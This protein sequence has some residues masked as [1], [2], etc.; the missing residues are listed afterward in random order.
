MLVKKDKYTILIII[1]SVLLV[2]SLV[3]GSTFAWFM[4]TDTAS[5][6]IVLGDPVEMI[7][8]DENNADSEDLPMV[9]PGS[10]LVPGMQVTVLAKVLFTQSNTPALLRAQIGARITNS[11]ADAQD[12]ADI[13]TQ[14]TAAM[15]S[16]VSSAGS[17]KWVYN[18][19]DD[20]WY[21][22]GANVIEGTTDQ[23]IMARIDAT[24]E[25]VSSRLVTFFSSSFVFPY[26][27]GNEF[28]N[29]DVEFSVEFQAVQG[30]LPAYTEELMLGENEFAPLD[31]YRINRI[32]NVVDIFNEAFAG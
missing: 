3:V 24:G 28:A 12:I 17:A 23:S 31:D 22:L 32:A 26:V 4:S 30:Y 9:I 19:G 5:Q 14:L 10:R 7:I 15:G 21:Y 6:S 2:I 20:W 27:V 29:S 1:L 13:E 16:A 11:T 8:V 18:S 25:T